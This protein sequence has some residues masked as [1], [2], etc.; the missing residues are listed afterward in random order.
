MYKTIEKNKF[1][2]TQLELSKK[3]NVSLSIVNSSVKKLE[4]IGAVKIQQRSFN[5]IDIKKIL[6]LWASLRNIDKDIILKIRIEAPVREIERA[7]PN[8]VFTAYTAYKLIFDEVPAD[9][10]EVYAYASDEELEIIKNRISKLKTSEN[11]PNLFILKKDSLIK[12]YKTL[13]LAQLFIDLWNLR[14]WYAK[15]YLAALEKKIKI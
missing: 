1:N 15:E 11:N 10:S 3:L 8:V 4:S 14:E 2:F 6:Y 5:V 13:P 7:L 12:L 9:Y